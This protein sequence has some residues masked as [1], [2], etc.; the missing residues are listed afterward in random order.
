M[1][2]EPMETM[3]LA[4]LAGGAGS[5]MGRPKGLLEVGGRPVLAFLLERLAWPG[6][7][8]LVTAPGRERP[9]GWNGFDAEAV[10]A[11][12]GDGPLRGVLTALEHATTD[13]LV[14]TAVDMPGVT[15]DVLA[16]LAGELVGGRPAT[17]VMASRAGEIEPLPCAVRAG[18]KPLVAARLAA[19][20]RSL[21]GLAAEPGVVVVAADD[22]DA[23]AWLNANTPGEWARLES[24]LGDQGAGRKI[25]NR[26]DDSMTTPE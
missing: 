9:P 4:V 10:D 26:N 5:R 14:V 3:T 13:V 18:A 15:R 16:W 22:R 21:H 6:P 12:A 20:R 2:R 8:L 11:V 25:R 23:S 7:T 19:G 1:E 24:Q 17:L